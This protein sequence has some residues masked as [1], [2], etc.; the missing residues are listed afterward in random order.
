[1]IFKKKQ[2]LIFKVPQID[3]KI[4]EKDQKINR[5]EDD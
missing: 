3:I 1:M 2:L 5:I 4:N